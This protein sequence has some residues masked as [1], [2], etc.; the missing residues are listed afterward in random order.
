MMQ[1]IVETK[2]EK[3]LVNISKPAGD[4]EPVIKFENVVMQ[5]I[6]VIFLHIQITPEIEQSLRMYKY[7]MYHP[8]NFYDVDL[9]D[10]NTRLRSTQ[11]PCLIIC[12]MQFMATIGT[13][14]ISFLLIYYSKDPKEALMNFVALLVI[15]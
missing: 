3:D 15:S 1:D 5:F 4:P 6:C 2:K 11:F 9:E 10:I 8:D 12:L 13:E 7:M 14:I